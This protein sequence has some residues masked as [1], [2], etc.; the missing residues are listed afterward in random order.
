M[1]HYLYA[2]RQF[3]AII[4]SFNVFWI[5][6]IQIFYINIINSFH[7]LRNDKNPA[8]VTLVKEYDIQIKANKFILSSSS[9]KN[10][11]PISS[12]VTLAILIL[13]SFMY[14]LYVMCKLTLL[15]SS[16]FL[17]VTVILTLFMY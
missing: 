3:I 9:I 16:T 15:R 6:R 10:I 4:K 11:L 1:I 13:S 12:I 14:R 8:D 2:L 17:L 7:E 5:L